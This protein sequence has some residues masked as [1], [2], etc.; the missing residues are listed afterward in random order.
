MKTG[1]FNR[2]EH[3]EP[4]EEN[5][6]IKNGSSLRLFS[7]SD[8]FAQRRRERREKKTGFERCGFD[9]IFNRIV[10]TGFQSAISNF[11]PCALRASAREIRILRSLRSLRLKNSMKPIE[12][13]QKETKATKK[14]L[15][16]LRSLLFNYLIRATVPHSTDL[17]FLRSLRLI[18]FPF[19]VVTL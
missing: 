19:F 4:R 15:C 8:F 9:G 11:F 12:F 13:Q 1:I 17:S 14:G 7:L 6:K 3:K 10:R 2:R 16:S 18:H 5:S